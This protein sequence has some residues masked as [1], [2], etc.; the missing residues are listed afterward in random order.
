[1]QQDCYMPLFF[2]L[3]F[4]FERKTL[5]S[6]FFLVTTLRLRALIKKQDYL[7]AGAITQH[8]L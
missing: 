6:F 7:Q 3:L 5:F 1:M 4:S 8:Y 2:I